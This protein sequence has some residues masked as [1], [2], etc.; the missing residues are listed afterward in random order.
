MPA[1][2][3]RDT[4]DTEDTVMKNVEQMAIELSE[5]IN[6]TNSIEFLRTTAR[7]LLDAAMHQYRLSP[8]PPDPPALEQVS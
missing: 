2:C 6:T 3:R 1:R 7:K 4:S 8:R 5:V